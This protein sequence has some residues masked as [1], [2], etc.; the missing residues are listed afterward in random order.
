V[1]SGDVEHARVKGQWGGDMGAW[2]QEG[3]LAALRF[4]AMSRRLLKVSGGH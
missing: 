2:T 4:A 1:R 3:Y